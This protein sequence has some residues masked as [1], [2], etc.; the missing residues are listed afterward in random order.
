LH[1]AVDF[2]WPERRLIVETD[3]P[4][5]HSTPGAFERDR[6]RDAELT[7]AG[8]RVLRITKRRLEQDSAAVTAQLRQLLKV[9]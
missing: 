5:T 7:V 1:W 2:A 9:R 4:G 6:L 8:W 3:A